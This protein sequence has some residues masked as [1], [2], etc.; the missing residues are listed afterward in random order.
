M[1]GRVDAVGG[2]AHHGEAAGG[3]AV[4]DVGRDAQAV[5][6]CR[7]RPHHGDAALDEL[8]EVGVPPH[9]QAVRGLAQPVDADRPLRVARHERRGPA[10]DAAAR[11]MAS[12]SSSGSRTSHPLRDRSCPARSR[13][14]ASTAPPSGA[15][16]S[17]PRRRARRGTQ[18]S[19]APPCANSRVTAA[20][21]GSVR[22]AQAARAQ[23]SS[24]SSLLLARL[25]EPPSPT[26]FVPP[27]PRAP[28]SPPLIRPAPRD[29]LVPRSPTAHPASTS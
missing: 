9:E 18:A 7:P 26:P 10:S 28:L 17:R 27:A 14:S 29:P 13:T 23:R 16:E 20:S 15:A 2:T 22:N 6:G 25:V 1:S 21:H 24:N 8:A 19:T 11:A 3:Q 5:L 12:R 4:G